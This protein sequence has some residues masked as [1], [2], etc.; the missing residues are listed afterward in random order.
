[1][2]IHKHT[3]H[4]THEF[5]TLPLAQFERTRDAGNTAITRPQE[6]AHFSY[7][8]SHEFRLDDSSIRWYYPPD[9]GTDLNR[10]FETFRKHDDSKDEHLDS[11][12]RALIE[13]E[14][15]TN[16]KTE[17]DVITWRGMM[18]KEDHQYKVKTRARQ[19]ARQRPQPGRPSGDAMSFW[20]Y[21]GSKSEDGKSTEWIE[22]KTTVTPRHRGDEQNFEKKLL[23]FWL[24][25][26]LLGVPHIIV[27]KRSPDG[28]LQSIE[29]INTAQIPG[30]VKKRGNNS[31]DGDMCINFANRFLEFIGDG[32]WKIRRREKSM[33]IEVFKTE[34][35][36]GHGGILS[37]EFVEWRNAFNRQTAHDSH[38]AN[39]TVQM[40]GMN[41]AAGDAPESVLDDVL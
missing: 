24:Q 6:I 30:M 37:D 22:L 8:D 4:H 13:K 36:E 21:K 11:L 12:L 41:I 34:E 15:V 10:G 1:M 19:D 25:S 39:N 27:G 14:K 28:I 26:F 32:V 20:V 18:T 9:L 2:N 40:N 16:V 31:W 5:N 29:R 17:A 38:V 7:D 33:A 3:H 23:K 35:V